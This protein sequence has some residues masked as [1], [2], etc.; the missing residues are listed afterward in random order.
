MLKEYYISIP[1]PDAQSAREAISILRH[2]F[3]A[4]HADNPTPILSRFFCSDVHAHAPLIDELW[5]QTAN[6]QRIYI[7]YAGMI[8]PRVDAYEAA[9]LGPTQHFVASKGIKGENRSPMPWNN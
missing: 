5:L 8:R 4:R 3:N 9:G 7:N 2:E 1:A 6:W